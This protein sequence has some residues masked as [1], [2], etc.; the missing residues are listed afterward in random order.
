MVED[1]PIGTLEGFRFTVAA[2][3]RAAD[4]RLLLAAAE[5]R[6]AGGAGAS[7][8]RRWSRRRTT[9]LA[10]I[11]IARDR[12]ARGRGAVAS[13]APGANLAQPRVVL[14]RALDVLDP[15]AR[16]AVQ[17]RLDTLARRRRSRGIC[18]CS[19]KLDAALRDPTAG[20]PLRARGRRVARG[21]RAAPAP[22]RRAA[23]R[24]A[25]ARRAQAAARDRRDDRH[26]RSVRARACSS[27]PRRGGGAMLMR[28]GRRAARGRHRAAA[29]RA[30]RGPRAW[31]PSAGQQAVRVDLVERI[32]RAAHDARKGREALRARPRARDLDRPPA[33]HAR[34]ADGA[35]R[36]PHRQ[37]RRG[38][39]AAMD[40]ARP[41][42]QRQ[43]RAAPPTD[44][45][46]AAL[47][48][49]LDG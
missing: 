45:A 31:L 41:D 42:P 3:A 25:R 5:K 24:G 15:P 17:A 30:G 44:N 46:F 16:K 12:L 47:A 6:L 9:T 26:A 1:H 11:A 36:L 48:G 28:A 20:A 4:K 27:P 18:R 35:A 10:L 33:R 29:R 2:D 21:R 19:S 32:A 8:A 39:P 49:M 22:R 13:L 38:G 23:G 40:V 34:A 14:D 43:A 7:A 37:A